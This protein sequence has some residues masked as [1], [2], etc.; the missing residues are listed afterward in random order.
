MNCKRCGNILNG[1]EAVCPNCGE[2][3]NNMNTGMTPNGMQPNMGQPMNSSMNGGMGGMP[4]PQSMP[5]QGYQQMGQPMMNNNMNQ[6]QPMNNNMNMNGGMGGATVP[7][8]KN[9][10]FIIIVII[11]TF[12]ISGLCGVIGY[13]FVSD[14]STKTKETDKDNKNNN[15][16]KK[17]DNNKKDDDNNK[18][19]DKKDDDNNKK[20]DD[21]NKDDDNPGGGV[22]ADNVFEV[23]DYSF[24]IPS[25]VKY[26]KED[27]LLTISDGTTYQANFTH[28]YYVY[29]DIIADPTAVL[30]EIKSAGMNVGNYAEQVV[31]GRKYFLIHVS[32]GTNEGIFY[33]SDLDG[34]SSVLGLIM[35]RTDDGLEKALKVVDQIADSA[36]AS[37]N[38]ANGGSEKLPII[39]F[40]KLF[41]KKDI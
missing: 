2:P 33:F 6:A 8:K 7:P 25:G 11:L 9:N 36:K 39:D 31:N 18:D 16:S 14:D 32:A 27:N 40:S 21:N 28:D 13:K 22:A 41:E 29:S 20:D 15:S 30:N 35:I 19:D 1:G 12:V 26:E 4:T 5:P 34:E 17:D 37:S 10:S 23:G 3:V 38:F 24:T